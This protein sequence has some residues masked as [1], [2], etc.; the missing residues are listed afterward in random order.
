[1]PGFLKL[2]WYRC[3]YVSVLCVYMCVCVCA[4]VC[5]CACVR[6]CCMS[7]FPRLLITS[8]VIWTPYGW[9]NTA[10]YGNCSH[11]QW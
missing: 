1:M 2:F 10:L 3:L 7:P 11:Y 5:V 8:S 4:R 9:L 6:V